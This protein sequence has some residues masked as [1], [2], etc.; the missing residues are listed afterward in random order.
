MALTATLLG[1]ALPSEAERKPTL[2]DPVMSTEEDLLGFRGTSS[3]RSGGVTATRSDGSS[4]PGAATLHP[5]RFEAVNLV[6]PADLPE[7]APGPARPPERP[8]PTTARAG[9]RPP[10]CPPAR[11]ARPAGSPAVVQE[12]RAALA[13]QEVGG[14]VLAGDAQGLAQPSRSPAQVAIG[15]WRGSGAEG[16]APVRPHR[17]EALEGLE[18]ADE[19]GQSL[20]SWPH[21]TLAH[22]C[23]P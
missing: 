13:G 10:R 18:G 22:Q 19:D 3:C 6:A 12:A 21:T 2:S 9:R 8:P 23:R 17:L 16:H 4:S 15:R 14:V 7:G 11:P 20:P 1:G 5:P